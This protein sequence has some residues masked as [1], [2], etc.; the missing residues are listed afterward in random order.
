MIRT[1]V[2]LTAALMLVSQVQAQDTAFVKILRSNSSSFTIDDG[3][4]KGPGG[5]ALAV[6]ARD[7]QFMMVGE[8]HGISEL[9]LFVGALFEAAKPAGY[10]H[11][12]V[13]IGPITGR[14]LETMMRAPDAQQQVDAFLGRYIPFS[15]PFFFWK[16]ESQM[17]ER[18]VKSV[19]GERG[20]V[21]GLDQEFIVSPTYMFER[22]AAI[23][24]NKTAREIATQYAAASMTGDKAMIKTGNPGAVWM[25]TATDADV[26]RLQSAF[27]AKPGSEAAEIIDEMSVSRDIYHMFNSGTNY[28]SNQKRDD[29]MKK[30]FIDAYNAAKSHG[31]KMPKAIIKLGA[32]HVFRGPS[33]TGSYEIGSFIPEFAATTGGHSFGI[34]VV[35]AKGTWNAYRP[36]GST[37]A[38]KTQKYDPLT[39]SEYDV[40]DMKSVLAAASP[41]DWTFIDLRPVRAMSINGRLKGIDPKARRLIS[42]FDAVV[43][44]P[45]G[46]ASDYFR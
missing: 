13:E 36:F 25:V 31:E 20:V 34:L 43:V 44:V 27:A 42:S 39:T 22:L 33:I 32:N 23:A 19:P 5:D 24:P 37:E 46:H 16:E 12:A 11:L 28:E 26:A 14:R 7:N 1:I 9:P 6:A 10:R 8:D 3:H 21:W 45:E 38:D 30:H 29:L 4:L 41:S 17:L 2:G 15:L 35:V 40:F 18:V